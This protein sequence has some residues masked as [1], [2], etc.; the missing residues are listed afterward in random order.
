MKI[1]KQLLQGYEN[2]RYVHYADSQSL[3]NTVSFDELPER[4]ICGVL[5]SSHRNSNV[6]R[7]GK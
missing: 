5:K 1:D 7:A 4:E 2:I 6:H 3:P